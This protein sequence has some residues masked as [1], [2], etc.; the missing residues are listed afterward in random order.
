MILLHKAKTIWYDSCMQYKNACLNLPSEMISQLDE[1][2]SAERRSRSF[3]VREIVQRHLD[4]HAELCRA[5]S[6]EYIPPIVPP[7]AD[8]RQAVEAH[9]KRHADLCSTIK[10]N[11]R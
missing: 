10:K 5:G 6:P 8:P 9:L 1:V 7:A 2:A 11:S 4:A 3:L